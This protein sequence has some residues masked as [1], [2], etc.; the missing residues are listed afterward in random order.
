VRAR[1]RRR[2]ESSGPRRGQR[3]ACHTPGVG[4]AAIGTD[5]RLAG[6]ER[7]EENGRGGW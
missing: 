3:D 6:S 1:V 5:R 4:S 2:A 7:P